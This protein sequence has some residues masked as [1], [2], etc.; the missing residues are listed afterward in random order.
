MYIYTYIEREKHVLH[1]T[2]I[3]YRIIEKFGNRYENYLYISSF[4]LQVSKTET[5]IS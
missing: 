5:H 1:R 2:Y 3:S 4:N